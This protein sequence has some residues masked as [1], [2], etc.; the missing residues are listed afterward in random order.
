MVVKGLLKF[1][2]N[3]TIAATGV[4]V[5]PLEK[6]SPFKPLFDKVYDDER[7]GQPTNEKGHSKL[8]EDACMIALRK[9][10]FVPD[11][12]DFL[13]IGDLVNQMTPSNFCA[14]ELQIPYV[15][16]F[17]ACA[18]SI[19]SL[20]TA[21]LLTE[22]GMSACSIAGAS[23]QHNA[24]ERQF[25]YPVEY[26]SQK[27]ETAQWTVTAA[28]VAA[29]TPNQAGF[30]AIVSGTIG[31]VIDLGVTDP[32]N[33]GAAMAPA[34]ADTLERHLNGHGRK[35]KHYDTIITGDLGKIGFEIYQ[36]LIAKKK[37]ETTNNLRDAGA[38]FFGDDSDFQAG[39]SG[40]GCS[41]AIYF[42]DVYEKMMV[43]EYKRVLLIATG[44][45][46]SPL[47][48]QQGDTIPCIAHAV[49]LEMK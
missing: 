41:A 46:L 27:P 49:E 2:T 14:S 10:G 31:R 15:G 17:S 13:L 11:D 44:S 3:P 6:K 19:S 8:V 48:F 37:I 20:L 45:L 42:S 33:M 34:A 32:F 39:A 7:S 43:G 5:G 9:A 23:S 47:S 24:V 35:V 1:R 29:V 40:T 22:S 38:E 30:P 12:A 21:A 18:T 16:M 26:G 25:R 28:G 36:K 4:V